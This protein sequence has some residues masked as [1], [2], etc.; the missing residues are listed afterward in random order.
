[1]VALVTHIVLSI[2]LAFKVIG[3]HCTNLFFYIV[4]TT[5]V[6]RNSNSHFARNLLAIRRTQMYIIYH[7]LYRYIQCRIQYLLWEQ[8]DSDISTHSSTSIFIGGTVSSSH[9]TTSFHSQLT[10]SGLNSPMTDIAMSSQESTPIYHLYQHQFCK[11]KKSNLVEGVS[12]A[13]TI[14]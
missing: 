4:C 10:T 7:V 12:F 1:M 2:I 6:S 11:A 8:G 13:E 5:V 9:A 3:R 14:H